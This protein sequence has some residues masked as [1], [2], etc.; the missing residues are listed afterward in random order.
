MPEPAPGLDQISTRWPLIKDPV[1]F[2]L[3]YAPAIQKYLEA[4]LRDSDDAGEVTQEFLLKG[5]LRGF[6]R[7]PQLRGRFRGYLKTAVRNAAFDHLQRRRPDRAGGLD[8]AYLPAPVEEDPAESEWAD[9]RRRCV[10][11][12]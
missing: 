4:L 6:V 11:D 5:L 2:V 9:A 10:L 1:Q 8:P 12:R 7:T 3:R